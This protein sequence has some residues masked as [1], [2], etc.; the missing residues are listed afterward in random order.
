MRCRVLRKRGKSRID[1]RDSAGLRNAVKKLTF[2]SAELEC[3]YPITG[4]VGCC[5]RAVSGHVAAA[6]PRTPRNSRRL[7]FA[8]KAQDEA[9]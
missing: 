2:V 3:R 8:P 6:P 7:M 5:A 1:F 9:S 4:M